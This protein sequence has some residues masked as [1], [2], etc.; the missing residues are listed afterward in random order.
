MRQHI[1]GEEALRK[2]F[3]DPV[4]VPAAV[5]GALEWPHERRIQHM[6]DIV[7]NSRRTPDKPGQPTLLVWGAEDRLPNAELAVGRRLHKQLPGSRLEVI[8]AAGHM[9]QV[10]QPER[11]IRVLQNFV[12]S[13]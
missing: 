10:E 9:P 6:L 11:F 4:K 1:Y 7:L 3:H 12:N 2:A 13:L 8:D 5:R